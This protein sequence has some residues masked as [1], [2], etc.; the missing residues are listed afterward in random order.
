MILMGHNCTIKNNKLLNMKEIISLRA[1]FQHTVIYTQAGILFEYSSL[2]LDVS[3]IEMA[4]SGR[5]FPYVWVL[6]IAKTLASTTKRQSATDWIDLNAVRAQRNRGFLI[7]V[8]FYGRRKSVEI[9]VIHKFP[10]LYTVIMTQSN[11][12][13]KFENLLLQGLLAGT[14]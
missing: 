10:I 7:F 1:D 5:H 11:L 6:F 9:S 12:K 14:L 13:F 4:P 8:T 2:I 3:I